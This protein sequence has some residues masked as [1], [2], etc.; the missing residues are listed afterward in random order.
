[1]VVRRIVL[2]GGFVAAVVCFVWNTFC[3]R[4]LLYAAFVSLCVMFLVSSVL[5]IGLEAISR[6]LMRFLQ[7]QQDQVQL[8][9]NEGGDKIQ[10]TGGG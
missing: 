2:L 4:E 9:E 6:I 5:N 10:N 8:D 1:M 7:A 3:D